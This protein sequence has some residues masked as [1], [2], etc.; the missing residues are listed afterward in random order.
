MSTASDQSEDLELDFDEEE[1]EETSLSTSFA[2]LE[3]SPNSS[4]HTLDPSDISF[5]RS[6]L[7]VLLVVCTALVAAFIPN[8]GL[9]VSLAGATSGTSLALIF[10]PLLEVCI[11]RQQ[12]IDISSSRFVFCVISIF[13]GILGAI[14]GTVMSLSAIYDTVRNSS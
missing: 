12:Q 14:L 11:S 7:R 9:L 10:P 13:I 3:S 2:D 1:E 5:I 6:F 8:I 4:L